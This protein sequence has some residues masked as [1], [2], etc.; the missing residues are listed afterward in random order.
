MCA[1]E[2][3]EIIEENLKW[4]IGFIRGYIESCDAA[5]AVPFQHYGLDNIDC[6]EDRKIPG[7][8]C[9]VQGGSIE[10]K[11]TDHI[12]KSACRTVYVYHCIV[13]VFDV[14][15]RPMTCLLPPCTYNQ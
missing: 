15:Q 11:V 14:I 4:F 8:F 5:D 6:E 12:F 3:L 9:N 10:G 7:R 2:G 1:I 13:I